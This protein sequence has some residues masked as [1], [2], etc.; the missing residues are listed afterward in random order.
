MAEIKYDILKKLG[1]LSEGSKGWKKEVNIISWN[2]KNA[3]ID[4]R[5]WD[6]EHIKM[7]KG[8]TL[9][10]TELKQLKEILNQIDI[11]E[12]DME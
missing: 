6:E 8:I 11:D 5:D 9:N 1:I 3:K 10:K 2:N 4:M 7:R 12:L